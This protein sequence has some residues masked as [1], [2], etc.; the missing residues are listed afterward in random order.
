MYICNFAKSLRLTRPHL[1]EFL[2]PEHLIVRTFLYD[3]GEPTPPMTVFIL[4][5][6]HPANCVD[7]FS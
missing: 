3:V 7:C 4:P 1:L 5:A 6:A 2:Q